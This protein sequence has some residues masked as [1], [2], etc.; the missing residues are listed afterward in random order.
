MRIVEGGS[1]C[2]IVDQANEDEPEI[3]D[4]I[5]EEMTQEAIDSLLEIEIGSEGEVKPRKKM[6][7]FGR[8]INKGSTLRK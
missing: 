6:T 3:D 2:E 5:E 8:K 7:F 4:T 1:K